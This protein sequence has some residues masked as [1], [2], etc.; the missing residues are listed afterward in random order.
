MSRRWRNPSASSISPQAEC[1]S[2]TQ[3]ID[4]LRY[5]DLQR[6][7]TLLE[8]LVVLA[9]IA[10]LAALILPSVLRPPHDG[11][12]HIQCVNN[13]KQEALAFRIWE[14]DNNDKYPMAV[15]RTNGGAM[16]FT[17]GPNV[18]RH[19]QV[20]SNE[21]STPK[22]LIC[23]QE[24]DKVRFVATNFDYFSNSNISY[25]VGLDAAETNPAMILSGDHNIT[26]GTAPGNGLLVLITNRPA[27]WT[28]EVHHKVGN[29]CLAD[30]S[31]WQDSATGLQDRIAHTGV[32]TNRLLMPIF[33]P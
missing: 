25:F 19:F 24:T 14:G 32:A 6:A 31:V 3:Q 17:S 5:R 20:M 12:M 9:V 10:V 28:T 1:H 11:S 29:V 22:V 15:S 26:N 23:P 21:L 30:G 2:A 16:E 18:F 4:N 7:M 27:G 33:G 8:L 13:L